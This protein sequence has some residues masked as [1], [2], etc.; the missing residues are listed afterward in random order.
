MYGNAFSILTKTY[1][2][3]WKQIKCNKYVC[4]KEESEEEEMIL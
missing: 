2:N 4:G 3:K 1:I